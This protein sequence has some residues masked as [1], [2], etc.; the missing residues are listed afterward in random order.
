M[1]RFIDLD[2]SIGNYLVDAD[3]N[4]FL[5]VY[6]Q[7]ASIPLGYNHPALHNVY[8]DLSKLVS[9]FNSICTKSFMQMQCCVSEIYSKSSGSS[10]IPTV[11]LGQPP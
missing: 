4:V 10:C 8:K 7:I 2:R 1:D 9:A 11:T 3:G 6:M 5:D